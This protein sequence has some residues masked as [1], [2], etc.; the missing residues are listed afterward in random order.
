MLFQRIACIEGRGLDLVVTAVGARVV[1][2]M[3]HAC[4]VHETDGIDSV[5]A[6]D[7]RAIEVESQLHHGFTGFDLGGGQAQAVPSV[8]PQPRPSKGTVMFA[9]L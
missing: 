5:V 1:S 6:R 2:P 4:T 8:F 9:P 7:S 3:R